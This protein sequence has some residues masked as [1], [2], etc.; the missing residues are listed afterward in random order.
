MISAP[1]EQEPRVVV[2]IGGVCRAW[3]P[4]YLYSVELPTDMKLIQYEDV[5][6]GD[7]MKIAKSAERL[8][9]PL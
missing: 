7:R 1:A 9:E 3:L 6:E 2:E 4:L 8:L 5:R